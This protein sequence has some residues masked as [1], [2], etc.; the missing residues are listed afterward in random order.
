LNPASARFDAGQRPVFNASF[1]GR[2]VCTSLLMLRDAI[3]I[4]APTT[5]ILGVDFQD[6]L[7][8][9]AASVNPV[10]QTSSGDSDI[11]RRLLVDR[12]G[13]RNPQREK[14]LWRD[15]LAA[16]ITIDALLD[17]ITTLLNQ[18]TTTSPT[19]TELGFNP[20]HEYRVFAG[21]EGYYGLFAAKNAAYRKQ[22]AAYAKPDFLN[23]S[24]MMVQ[25]DQCLAALI[26]LAMEYR[27]SLIVYIHPYHASFLDMLDRLGLW[28]G[29]EAWKRHLV[30]QIASLRREEADIRLIDFSG[31]NEFTTEAVPPAG[32]TVSAMRWYWEAG[33]YKSALGEHML[34]RLIDGQT[35][36]GRSLTTATIDG[37][38][39][40][41][42]EE[43]DRFA[44]LR[45]LPAPP[46]HGA[47]PFRASG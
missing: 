39:A 44:R 13:N 43:R 8:L 42:R 7:T 33:H 1:P 25:A 28:D 38:L 16:T 35:R 22:Y 11:E 9:P 46:G 24:P 4:R 23:P 31:Y 21:R 36:F 20:L 19:L 18:N 12:R 10:P 15:R 34:E 6:W 3:A 47:A 14:Q 27:I 45:N 29:F 40:E 26:K 5:V 32:D 17:S 41:I 30:A 37:A 2:D